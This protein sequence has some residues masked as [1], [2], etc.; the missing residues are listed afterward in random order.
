MLA[1]LMLIAAPAWG[2]S[3]SPSASGMQPGY[4]AQ[5]LPIGD[6]PSPE[7]PPPPA[8]QPASQAQI[9][10][11]RQDLVGKPAFSAGGGRIGTVTELS[12]G[13]DDRVIAAI[14]TTDSGARLPVSWQR[15]RVQLGKP[16][17]VVPWSQ[18]EIRWLT[19]G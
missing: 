16:T 6:G 15:A 2:Q 7:P 9:E 8:T 5:D 19:R 1:A 10:A 13:L 17:L 11:W 18:S 3:F 12:V 14:V 4:S